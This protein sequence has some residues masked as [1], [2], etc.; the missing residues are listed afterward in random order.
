MSGDISNSQDNQSITQVNFISDTNNQNNIAQ[1]IVQDNFCRTS[2]CSNAANLSATVNGENNQ[3][4]DQNVGQN[5][6]C[7]DSSTCLNNGKVIGASGSNS[8]S[9][10]CVDGSSCNNSGTNNK[11][12]CVTGAT[13][14]NTGVNT[15]VISD[16]DSCNSGSDGSTTICSYGRIVTISSNPNLVS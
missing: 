5:N 16:G 3:N 7:L 10:V 9:N 1:K 11:N 12:T 4:I 8:Q 15:K 13:C 6:L 2:I 14:N